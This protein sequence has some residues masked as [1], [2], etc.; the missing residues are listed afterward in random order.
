MA[1]ELLSIQSQIEN[2]QKKAAEIKSREFA[3]TVQEIQETMA[4]FGI[5][6]KDLQAPAKKRQGRAAGKANTSAAKPKKAK[7]GLSGSSVAAK[8]RG[9]NGETWSGRGL[10]PKWLRAAVDA[11]QAK[12]SFLIA[13]SG[14]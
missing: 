11:G 3:K 9:P 6:I 7:S 12:E 13:V 8:Y 1:K 10:M 2:L 5:T 4:A 14:S